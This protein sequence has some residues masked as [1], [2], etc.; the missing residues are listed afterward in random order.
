MAGRYQRLPIEEVA[1][2]HTMQDILANCE[3]EGECQIWKGYLNHRGTPEM[4]FKGKLYV[5]RAVVACLAGRAKVWRKGVWGTS[6]TTPGCVAED[7][8]IFRSRGQHLSHR[9]SLL[10]RAVQQMRYASNANAQPRKIP[11]Q[12][13]PLIKASNEPHSVLAARYGC[14]EGLIRSYR[15]KQHVCEVA[16]PWAGLL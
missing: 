6:C 8:V 1:R 10:P 16:S 7:H 4:Y 5:V 12:D 11:L 3:E 13:I 2:F 9:T 14:S 15:K